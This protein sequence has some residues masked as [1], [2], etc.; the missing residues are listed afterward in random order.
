MAK[1]GA[2]LT[3][4]VLNYFHDLHVRAQ[5]EAM[6]F[7]YLIN[8]CPLDSPVGDSRR[9]QRGGSDLPANNGSGLNLSKGGQEDFL[10]CDMLFR[11]VPNPTH[12]ENFRAIKAR[13]SDIFLATL[14]PSGMAKMPG[15]GIISAL[16][17]GFLVSG[18]T[19]FLPW[20][21]DASG[22]N[23]NVGNSGKSFATFTEED[24]RRIIGTHLPFEW[25]PTSVLNT[26]LGQDPCKV[27]LVVREP[28]EN[29]VGM[30]AFQ[31][32]P[33][34]SMIDAHV[35]A[36]LGTGAGELG[37]ANRGFAA[38]ANGYAA[39]LGGKTTVTS[40]GGPKVFLLSQA[41]LAN[42]STV[43]DEV[44]RLAGFL[45]VSDYVEAN[46]ADAISTA[47]TKAA[48]AIEDIS[49]LSAAQSALVDETFAQPLVDPRVTELY[50]AA[51][52]IA[53]KTPVAAPGSDLLS[54]AVSLRFGVLA[55]VLY[56]WFVMW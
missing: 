16:T 39:A 19:E 51:G 15:L 45:E 10:F 27:I 5:T 42:P 29:M 41:R 33:V 46:F 48:G 22:V 49:A 1:L 2:F 36:A 7:D 17:G 50:M 55:F 52:D 44:K 35:A 38:Y 26:P 8:V 6:N 12:L 43:G 4:L 20:E 18:H 47:Q 30:A 34:D 54:S 37:I 40:N 31:E 9:L 23:M 56:T 21:K 14:P 11:K 32:E 3:M 24:G 53:D 28:K 25:L 13:P